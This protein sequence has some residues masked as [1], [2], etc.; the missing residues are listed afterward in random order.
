VIIATPHYWH[1]V[2]TVQAA[3]AGLHV[4][5]EKPLA[6][7]VGPARAMIAEC[8]KRK[9]ALGAVLHQRTRSIMLKMKQLIDAGTIGKIYRVEMVCS[10]WYRTQIYYDTGKWRGTWDGEGGGV[11]LNQAPHSLDLFQWIG[12]MP[13]RVHATLS[14]RMHRIEVEN[15]AHLVCQYDQPT[16]VGSFFATTAEAPG[17]EELTVVGDKGTLVASR[18]K[19]QFGKLSKPI[20]RALPATKLQPSSEWSEIDFDASTPQ[21]HMEVVKAFA[22]HLC[23]GTP[24][25]AT[26]QDALN[27][28]ELSNSAY[29]SGY[30]GDWV[31]IPVDAEAFDRLIV[32]LIRQKST[33]RGGNIRAHA[34]REFGKLFPKKAR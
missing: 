33:G 21:G 5:C 14:T 8:K 12:G 7:S 16:R 11:L 9:V 3:R 25:I 31:D 22:R 4:L 27:E 34:N 32:K 1:P 24:M 26:G 13:N 20:S 23:N 10:N 29:L 15:T 6:V 18:G 17:K 30:G 2:L 19:I 28:L